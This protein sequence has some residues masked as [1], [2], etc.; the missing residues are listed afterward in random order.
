MHARLQ[1]RTWLN[2]CTRLMRWPHEECI[3]LMALDAA[4]A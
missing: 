4:S 2:G 3:T 1:S